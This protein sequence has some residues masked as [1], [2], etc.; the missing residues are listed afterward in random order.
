MTTSLYPETRNLRDTESNVRQ[1]IDNLQEI[2]RLREQEDISDFNNLPQR[3]VGGRTGTR[4]PTD[5]DSV[6][7]TDEVGDVV[8]DS[9]YEYKL[10][11]ETSGTARWDR[12][13]E[14]NL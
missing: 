14:T 5:P 8:N 10:V 7:A 13:W 11:E 2:A 6:L 12:D 1:I 4:V 9:L 3:F